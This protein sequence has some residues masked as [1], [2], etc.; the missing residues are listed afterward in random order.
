MKLLL[1]SL[2]LAASPA[3][4]APRD[5]T[6]YAGCADRALSIYFP[7]GSAELTPEA[8]ATVEGFADTLGEC[9]VTGVETRAIA[10]DAP[11]PSERSQLEHERRMAVMDALAAA[12]LADG[13]HIATAPR[14]ELRPTERTLPIARRVEV[15][16]DLAPPALG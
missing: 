13:E 10:F 2:A 12:N 6:A 14:T 15:T 8:H 9:R 11:H 5:Q 3:A 16:F 4:D 7:A 1:A